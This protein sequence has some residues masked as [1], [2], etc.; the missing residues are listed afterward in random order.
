M[1]YGTDI[2]NYRF[3]LLLITTLFF[4]GC[5][6]P[7]PQKELSRPITHETKQTVEHI[8]TNVV[9][10]II[11]VALSACQYHKAFDSWPNAHF[12][13]SP[14]SNFEKFEILSS[15][16]YFH[17][18]FKLKGYEFIFNLYIGVP[19]DKFENDAPPRQYNAHNIESEKMKKKADKTK[20][21]V[22]K[23][24][25]KLLGPNNKISQSS[26]KST[27]DC[28]YTL[29]AARQNKPANIN[30]SGSITPGETW[31][32]DADRNKLASGFLL[33]SAISGPPPIKDG[34][35]YLDK[36]FS[37][38]ISNAFIM[39]ALCNV[40]GIEPNNCR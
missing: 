37:N 12:I 19:G 22:S 14:Q 5:S 34:T 28:V 24:L 39:I 18:E 36:L 25:Y 6:N 38:K 35:N 29:K 16:S 4:M 30:L 10:P 26:I 7:M 33:I 40:L 9:N 3:Y 15:K 2:L 13:P 11:G 8:K 20:K 1:S 23:K 32:S 31:T 27:D 17:S 21:E